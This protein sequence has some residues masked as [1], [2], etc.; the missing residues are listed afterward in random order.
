MNMQ[1]SISGTRSVHVHGDG[2]VAGVGVYVN[3]SMDV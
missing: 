2:V 1:M 3:R